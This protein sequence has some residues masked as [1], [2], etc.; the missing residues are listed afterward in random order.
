MSV[1]KELQFPATVRW[2]GGKLVTAEVR[3]G[4]LPV[5]T[6]PEFAGGLAGHWSPEDMLVAAAAS[7]YAL[8]LSAVAERR[9]APLLDALISATGHM[10]RRS[11][12]RFGFTLIEISADLETTADGEEAVRSA[13]KAAEERCLVT[14]AL[15][16]P[17]HVWVR[18]STT[19]PRSTAR[20]HAG[21]GLD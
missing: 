17:V 10:S 16:I 9:G 7:C 2:R 8:T 19:A 18:V 1:M 15:W 13:A 4:V 11:D 20:L 12:G 21:V 5:A 3:A 14:D 6:P